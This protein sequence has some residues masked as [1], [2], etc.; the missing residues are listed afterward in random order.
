MNL[1]VAEREPFRS[2]QLLQLGV[3][4]WSSLLVRGLLNH[5]AV[6]TWT[7]CSVDHYL[8]RQCLVAASQL[9]KSGC[10]ESLV[11]VADNVAPGIT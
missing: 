10:L 7:S 5:G 4:L 2:F 6:L 3:V 11:I 9:E 8:D 1:V